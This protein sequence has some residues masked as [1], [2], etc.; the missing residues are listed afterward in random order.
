[1]ASSQFKMS[2]LP[3]AQEA[4]EQTRVSGGICKAGQPNFRLIPV[5]SGLQFMGHFLQI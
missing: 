5:K 1:M 3:F 2:V 4:K